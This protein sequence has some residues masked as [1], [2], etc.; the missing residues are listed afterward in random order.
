MCY[1]KV[2]TV[3]IWPLRELMNV[4]KTKKRYDAKS[5]KKVIGLFYDKTKSENRCDGLIILNDIAMTNFRRLGYTQRTLLNKCFDNFYDNNLKGQAFE[6]ACR[7]MLMEKGLKAVPTRVDLLEPVLPPDISISLYGR[8]KTRTDI[9]LIACFN[10][11]LLVVECKEIKWQLPRLHEQNLFRKYVIEQFY[12]TK[13]ISAD[14]ERFISYVGQG[15]WLSLEISNNQP[16]RLFPLVISNVVVEIDELE[17][18][19]IFTFLELKDM[20]SKKWVVKGADEFGKFEIAVNGKVV[21]LP[22]FLTK[23]KE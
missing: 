6:D 18:A 13:W 4:N 10:N 19:P 11:C 7:K 1:D 21:R 15:N 8:Q 5:F 14:L 3:G 22:W 20:V 16:L 9:D 2:H 17:T 23:S 12:R